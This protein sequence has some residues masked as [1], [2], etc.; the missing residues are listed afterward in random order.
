MK[1]GYVP[2]MAEELGLD[3]G[4]R[5]KDGEYAG[6]ISCNEMLLYKIPMD[7]YQEVMTMMHH[8]IP[9]DD[10]ANI[11]RKVEE[12]QSRDNN[13]RV[14]GSVEGDGLADIAERRSAPVFAG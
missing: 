14:L 10:A 7:V 4:S 8:D 2:V 11:K 13:G 6:F 12:M 9:N 5:V 3:A 1:L